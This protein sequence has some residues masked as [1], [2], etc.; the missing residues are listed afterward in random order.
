M[1]TRDRILSLFRA[2]TDS[3]ISGQEIS[4]AL[5]VSRAAVW[6]QV[7][8][9]RGLGF[10]IEARHSRGYRLVDIQTCCWP[11]TLKRDSTVS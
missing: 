10:T 4:K 7:E 5:N 11:L 1:S 9:L 3:F 8:A 2:Q 6:K